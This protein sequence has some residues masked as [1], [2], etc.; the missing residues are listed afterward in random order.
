MAGV[1]EIDAVAH[2]RIVDVGVAVG[3]GAYP[4]LAAC[5]RQAR[6]DEAERQRQGRHAERA[7]PAEQMA[8]GGSC[9]GAGHRAQGGMTVGH[10]IRD[11]MTAGCHYS[12]HL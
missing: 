6:A 7:E 11:P 8:A 10:S 2:R 1:G 4:A 5:P 9:F 3:V 12:Q